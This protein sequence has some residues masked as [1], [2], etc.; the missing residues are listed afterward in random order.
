MSFKK[1]SKNL[2]GLKQ[3]TNQNSILKAQLSEI[4]KLISQVDLF[5]LFNLDQTFNQI[6]NF[7]QNPIKKYLSIYIKNYQ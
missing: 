7:K 5:N 3:K 4:L 6:I 1:K 2:Q